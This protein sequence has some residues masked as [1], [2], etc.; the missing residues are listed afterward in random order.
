[1][2]ALSLEYNQKKKKK[3]V[4]MACGTPG[5]AKNK[6]ALTEHLVVVR[7]KGSK[8]IHQHCQFPQDDV[9]LLGMWHV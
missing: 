7:E 5:S 6:H 3:K 8:T 1:M 9:F 2:D 4:A